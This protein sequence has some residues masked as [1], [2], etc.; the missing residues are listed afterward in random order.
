MENDI[1]PLHGYEAYW[2]SV[3][4]VMPSIFCNFVY[5]G[6]TG[7]LVQ[8]SAARHSGQGSGAIKKPSDEQFSQII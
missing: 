6:A 1:L 5:S 3:T 2:N 8:T 4:L 7:M